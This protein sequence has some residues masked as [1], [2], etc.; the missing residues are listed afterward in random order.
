M[1]KS[2]GLL[3]SVKTLVGTLLDIARTR[4]E[5]LANEVEE[6]R[7]RIWQVLIFS[8]LTLFFFGLAVVLLT[9]FVVVLFWDDH[10]L[11]VLA[12]FTGLY[13]VFGL[14]AWNSLR[15]VSRARSKLFSLSIS[16]LNDDS[17]QLARRP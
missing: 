15:R 16:E 11:W 14:L 5:L 3:E 17:E 2:G 4:L 8:S 12:L 6:E 9:S 10:R 1:T 7:L 13:S